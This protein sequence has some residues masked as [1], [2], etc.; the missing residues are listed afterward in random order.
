MSS[1][2][3]ERVKQSVEQG[4]FDQFVLCV[5]Y[6]IW[7]WRAQTGRVNQG[8][9]HRERL[10]DHHFDWLLVSSEYKVPDYYKEGP[11]RVVQKRHEVSPES[12]ESTARYTALCI[13]QARAR[14][15]WAMAEYQLKRPGVEISEDQ[16]RQ[17]AAELYAAR[18]EFS[19][20]QNWELGKL[21][22]FFNHRIS[23]AA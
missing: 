6:A 14:F 4:F 9:E 2:K 12:F 13:S 11:F 10:G 7:Y 19:D 21:C 23:T 16:L 1:T 22:I 20:S 18:A 5:A 8:D 17:R 3:S 15:D